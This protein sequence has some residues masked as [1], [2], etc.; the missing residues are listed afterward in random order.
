MTFSDFVLFDSLKP[1]LKAKS[2]GDVIQELVRA[3]NAA[4]A[5]ADD[6]VEDVIGAITRREELGS[7]AIGHGVAVPH[8][9]H[10]GVD[11]L[12]A[13]IGVSHDGVDFDALDEQTVK[14][15]I[16]LV[17]PPDRPGDHL[18]ALEYITTNL[19]VNEFTERLKAA[20]TPEEMT[21]VLKDA[22]ARMLHNS[23]TNEE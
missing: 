22:D 11:R 20:I 3:L 17:S 2:K 23:D 7:T 12:V 8:T 21:Q 5:I 4:G 13:V 18:R 19:K 9:K 15:F 16:M 10:L 14:I 1:D 6:L